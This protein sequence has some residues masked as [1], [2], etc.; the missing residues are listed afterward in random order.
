MAP[1]PAQAYACA[2]LLYTMR[3]S[4][5]QALTWGTVTAAVGSALWLAS[6]ESSS[7]RWSGPSVPLH[8][9]GPLTPA[10]ADAGYHAVGQQPLPTA[11]TETT[12]LR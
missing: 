8:R 7:E 6:L 1:G 4:T 9:V 5:L 11:K 10:S 3:H 12:A 2:L